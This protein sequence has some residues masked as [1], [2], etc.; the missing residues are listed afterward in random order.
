[1]KPST[2]KETFKGKSPTKSSKTGKSATVPEPIEKPIAE[3]VMD[4]LESTA[5]EDVVNDADLPQ[6]YVAPKT[7]KLSRDTWFKQPPRPPTPDLE[8]NKRQVITDQPEHPWFNHMVSAAKYP[9]TFDELMATPINFSKYDMNRLQVDNVTQ[10]ILV[11][12][13][14]NLLKGT[15]TSS[16]ELKY[17]MEECFKALKDRLDWNNPE[18]DRC[19]FYLTK[20]LPWK[21]RPGHLTI[22]AEYFFNNDLEFLKSSESEKKYTT[23]ITK[24]KA[25]RYKIVGIK[26][27]VPTLWSTIKV[28]MTKMLKRESSTGVKGLFQLDVSDIIDL[29]VALHMFTRSLII[30]HRVEDIKLGVESYQK[31]LNITAPQKT[32]PEIEF[33]ELYTPSY[34]P[35]WVIYEDLNKQKR[36]M[37]ADELYKFSDE[38]LK[39]I[40][41][42]LHHRIL[43]F[44]LG[45]NKEMS[46]IK[47]VAIDKRR[48][49]LMV[50]LFDKQIRERRIIR[51]LERLIGA[52][53][54][55]MDYRLMT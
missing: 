54:L 12:P 10:K 5:N 31:K 48:S 38:T 39:T 18:G 21:G 15:C 46:R 45:Y 53:E 2:T 3:V 29:I 36:V 44:R 17:N 43:D 22:A 8:W 49:E 34:K 40:R 50:E 37:R 51:N 11:G 28:G 4:N 6:Y 26:D 42:E 33:K 7:N 13:V 20:P 35:P 25:A 14:Y 32:F 41:D 23:S 47:W 30:K 55:E 1:M 27:M 24:T 9:L 16:I 19:P 52:W